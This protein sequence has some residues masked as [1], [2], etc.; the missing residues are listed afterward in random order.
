[1]RTVLIA[2]IAGAFGCI[3]VCNII[4]EADAIPSISGCKPV[5]LDIRGAAKTVFDCN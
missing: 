4:P 5:Y 3:I 1:M 2:A